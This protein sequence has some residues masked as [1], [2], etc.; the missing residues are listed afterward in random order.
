MTSQPKH[1]G[2][3]YLKLLRH[4]GLDHF[5]KLAPHGHVAIQ[6]RIESANL[7]L[8]LFEQHPDGKIVI[9]LRS[10]GD[11]QKAGP[12][13]IAH[14]PD[15]KSHLWEIREV[16]VDR[17]DRPGHAGIEPTIERLPG[18]DDFSLRQQRNYGLAG[19]DDFPLRK[20]RRGGK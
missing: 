19:S 20:P 8:K 4:A 9:H 2:S 12:I 10:L 7:D 13:T 5:E 15:A 3:E 17:G 6:Q 16:Q 1:P 11:H 18:S 14:L